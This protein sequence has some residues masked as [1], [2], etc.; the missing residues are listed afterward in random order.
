M[1]GA[2]CLD[3]RM[4]F[5][6]HSLNQSFEGA[7]RMLRRP[8]LLGL[9]GLS[10]LAP[11]LVAPAV[12][13]DATGLEVRG[14]GEV[15]TVLSP[16][17]KGVLNAAETLA[18]QAGSY[19]G[20][21]RDQ[22][23]LFRALEGDAATPGFTPERL[24]DYFVRADLGVEGGDVAGRY[25]PGNRDDVVVVRDTTAGIPHIEGD[26]RAGAMF[27]SGYTTAED[28]LFLMDLLRHV[29]R[30][31]M[32]EFL[33][34]SPANVRMDRVQLAVAPYREEDYTA[35]IE[36]L[37][38]GA[39]E[40]RQLVAD[41]EDYSAGVNAYIAEALVDPT[42]LPAE[43]PALQQLPQEWVPEDAV[44]IAS[45]IAANFGKGGGQ[46][47]RNACTLDAMTE[48]LG[49]Y[50]TARAVFDDMVLLDDPETQT[51][52]RSRF[53][54]LTDLG[55]VDP[56]SVPP[57]DCSTLGPV[58][59]AGLSVEEV[60]DAVSGAG[61]RRG[62]YSVD[63]PWGTVPFN[64]PQQ[65][66]N[67]LLVTGHRSTSG[68]PVASM[69]PQISFFV[70]ELFLEKEL[71]APGLLARGVGFA[72]VDLY[73]LV[74]RGADFA[75]SAT[76]SR[77][78]IID[79]FV[80]RLC[81][82]GGGTPTVDSTG[83]ERDGE[84]RPIERF[85][86]TQVAKPSAGG[87]P[88]QPGDLQ[89]VV[90]RMPVERTA[91]YGPLI[92]RGALRD[93]TPVAVASLRSTYGREL[94]SL[95]AFQKVNDPDY[96]R[97]GVDA[98]RRAFAEDVEYSFNWLYLDAENVGYQHSCRCPR[99]APGSD[100]YRPTWGN[101]RWDW[102]GLLDP[103]DQ[104]TVVDP[105]AGYLT[106]WNNKPAP[107]FGAS[108]D[109]FAWGPDLRSSL[110]DKGV[111]PLLQQGRLDRGDVLDVTQEAAYVD[112]RARELLPLLQRVLGE[113]PPAAGTDP[114]AADLLRR[115][116]AWSDAGG[117]RRDA[118]GDG[119]YEHAVAVAAMDAWWPRIVEATLEAGNGGAFELLG[120][121]LHQAPQLGQGFA[122]GFGPY[123]HVDKDLRQVLG[124][125][126]RGRFSRTYCG[127]GDRTTCRAD[128]WA[129][130]ATAAA[131]LE[132]E[133]ASADVDDWQR[134][135][136]DDSIRHSAAGVT[137][138]PP[139]PFQNRP[140]Y[141]IVVEFADRSVADRPTG[142][143]PPAPGAAGPRPLGRSLPSTGATAPLAAVA[144]LAGA[145]ALSRA[146][147][148]RPTG[149]DA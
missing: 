138:L 137:T 92:A 135:V 108:D 97:G 27:A 88:E 58:D 147:R 80:V 128:L 125:P 16:G 43:Y 2:T 23:D 53:P 4:R 143:G 145:T 32:S 46:E 95:L 120:A 96:M 112:L 48:R 93:G 66:S 29:G 17:Q 28:R 39:P 40:Q 42:K 83:Y 132:S 103:A 14:S 141:Q 111:E 131:D 139:I 121:P 87:R 107:G 75:F 101:G 59:P 76:S 81:D 133:F 91:D 148:R 35:Q 70:P 12:A 82:P 124:D 126:V 41:Y 19:P 136:L 102:R 149:G 140:T 65:T 38:A 94:P 21:V 130:L 33:G 10:V 7:K 122:F 79:D 3:R 49:D 127:R 8:A 45:L 118:D 34:A 119:A 109:N 129:S 55:P 57:I 98:F 71:R 56:A 73:V 72:G 51:T 100:P 110:L 6:S 15:H 63:T 115:T 146:L 64:L 18:A 104:P 5:R 68:R 26:T 20:H 89:N 36:E 37:R 116:L 54:Y 74:G 61:A 86:H 9:T 13:A 84:C 90:L 47:L 113:T 117:Q 85:V 44:A 52:T 105:P 134:A 1:P 69:G 114:R 142:A 30:A 77:A 67:G 25:A 106:S 62:E 123:P 22:Y 31:R 11:L 24:D 50:P 78:D 60:I 144:L 99:R